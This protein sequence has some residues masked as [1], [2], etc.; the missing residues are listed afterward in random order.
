MEQTLN[1]KI[2]IGT[3]LDFHHDTISEI[4]IDFLHNIIDEKIELVY[5]Y[6]DNKVICSFTLNEFVSKYLN[7]INYERNFDIVQSILNNKDNEG[8]I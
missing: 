6:E 5:S 8:E 2:P 7:R 4:T 1:L 3:E